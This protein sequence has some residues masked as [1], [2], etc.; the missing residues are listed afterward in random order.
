M[1]KIT[2]DQIDMLL[3]I[4]D[5][6]SLVGGLPEDEYDVAEEVLTNDSTSLH[7]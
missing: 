7:T 3:E 4:G 1:D 6:F 2:L 5:R